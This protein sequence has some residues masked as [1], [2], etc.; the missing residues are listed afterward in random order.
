[1]VSPVRTGLLKWRRSDFGCP[2]TTL[3][4]ETLLFATTV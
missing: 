4:I 2:V 1:M 3:Q